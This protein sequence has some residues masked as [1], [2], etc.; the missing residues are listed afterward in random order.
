MRVSFHT[1]GCKLNQ[2]ETEALASAFRSQGFSLVEP[3][4]ESDLY[5]VN[6]CTG[7]GKSEQ[8]ARR[9]IRGL[10]RSRPEALVVVTGC[11][12]QLD[13]QG[14]AELGPNVSVV[15]QSEKSLLLDLPQRLLEE[16]GQGRRPSE[17][18]GILPAPS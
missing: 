3:S 8:K 18:T 16:A 17:L 10:S 12:A 13:P 7:T 14:L 5:L 9:Y 2:F 11:Y 4:E 15:S 6:T 1:F